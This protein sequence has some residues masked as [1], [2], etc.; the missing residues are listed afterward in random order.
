MEPARWKQYRFA[1]FGEVG[2]SH[3][4]Y[5]ED[6]SLADDC[7]WSRGWLIEYHVH[8][9][10]VVLGLLSILSDRILSLQRQ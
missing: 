8:Y 6:S 10:A 5:Q 2:S 3:E 1:S 7:E 9:G 4:A